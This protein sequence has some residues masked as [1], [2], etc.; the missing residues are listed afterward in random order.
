MLFNDFSST[1]L[2]V[3]ALQMAERYNVTVTSVLL[4]WLHAEGVVAIPRAS[5]PLHL[6][7]NAEALSS[8]LI[9]LDEDVE[10]IRSLDRP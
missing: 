3:F 4:G 10:I 7:A 9:I 1:L 6:M 2:I 5:N 8:P